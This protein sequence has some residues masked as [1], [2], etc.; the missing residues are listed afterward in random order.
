MSRVPPPATPGIRLQKHLAACGLGSRRA[1]EE[2]ILAGRVRV[3]GQPAAVLGTRV[4]PGRQTVTVDGSPVRVQAPVCLMLN[5]P[6][7]ILCT[8]HDPQGRQTV[9]DLLRAAAAPRERLYTVGR[10]DADSEGLILVTNDGE[11]AHRLA[12]PRH[13]VVKRY[14]VW[15]DRPLDRQQMAQLTAGVTCDGERL[16]ARAVQ[17]ARAPE[18]GGCCR[19]DLAEGRKRQIRRMLKALGVEVTRLRR[20]AVGPLEL[21]RLAPGAWRR[22]EPAEW[23]RLRRAAGE[24]G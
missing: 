11:L 17:P 22:L 5:K 15:T 2:L 18:G 6:H 24:G 12:H 19:V 10:L 3:D 14:L 16:T 20:V 4:D 23:D 13:A 21:G 9:L 1:C 7:G 8:S